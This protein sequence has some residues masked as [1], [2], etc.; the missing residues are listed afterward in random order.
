MID[1]NIIKKYSDVGSKILKNWL[2]VN[3]NTDC[4]SMD[5]LPTE[6]QKIVVPKRKNI[7]Q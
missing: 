1:K 6:T 2:G 5:N 4:V 7:E 3:N